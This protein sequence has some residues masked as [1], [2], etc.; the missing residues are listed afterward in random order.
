MPSNALFKGLKLW[1]YSGALEQ[2]LMKA[3]LQATN[4][5]QP[6]MLAFS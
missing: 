6:G 2:L 5:S 4:V 3:L 1:N